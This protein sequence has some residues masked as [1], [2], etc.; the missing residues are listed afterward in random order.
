MVAADESWRQ[1]TEICGFT[2]P[3][4]YVRL[5]GNFPEQLRKTPRTPDKSIED[6]FVAE[7]ELLADVAEVVE[8]NIEARNGG[9]IDPDGEEFLWPEQ[10]LVIGE[11]GTGDYYCL[12]VSGEHTGVLQY[13]HQAIEFE[14]VA[15]SLE[16]FVDMLLEAYSPNSV[17]TD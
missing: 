1:L 10:L 15:E 14:I 3:E 9:V 16:D 11:T 7:V 8:I 12:D 17:D 4:D 2:I 6:G 13:L 5:L